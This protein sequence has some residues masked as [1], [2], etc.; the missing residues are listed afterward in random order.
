MS[1]QTQT[2]QS[3]DPHGVCL[4]ACRKALADAGWSCADEVQPNRPAKVL[5]TR[6]EERMVIGH[7][8]GLLAVYVRL[9][10][11]AGVSPKAV[12]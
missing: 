4:A 6:G 5:A 3:H 10:M 9:C 12:V 8:D 11:L 1:T 2:Q 7:P